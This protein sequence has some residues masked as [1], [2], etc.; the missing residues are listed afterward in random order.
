M[1]PTRE[2]KIA[3]IYEVIAEKWNSEI[4]DFLNDTNFDDYSLYSDLFDMSGKKVM[5]WDLFARVE[6]KALVEKTWF[7]KFDDFCSH[8]VRM[9]WNKHRL[10]IDEQSDWCVDYIYSLLTNG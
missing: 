3:K 10:P 8:I 5:I 9:V 7:K 6:W 2:E 1:T 4:Q